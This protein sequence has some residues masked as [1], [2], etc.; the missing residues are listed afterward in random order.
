MINFMKKFIPIFVLVV[1][2]CQSENDLITSKKLETMSFKNHDDFRSVTEKLTA[3]SDVELDEWEKSNSFVSFR[4]VLNTAYKE[5]DLIT[6]EEQHN[7]FFKKYSD[8]L[9]IDNGSLEPTIK[10]AS[11]R[12]FVNREGLY[13]TEGYLNK[14][15]GDYIVSGPLLEYNRLKEL[16]RESQVL[17]KMDG[18]RVYEYTTSKEN[19]NGR[20]NAACGTNM[21]ASYFRNESNCR[22]DR[23]V[24]LY[25]NSFRDIVTN[26]SGTYYYPKVQIIVAP[27]KRSGTFCNWSLYANP[28]ELRNTS[29]SVRAYQ[30]I[31]FGST[32]TTSQIITYSFTLPYISQNNG[33]DWTQTIGDWTFNEPVSAFPFTSLHAEGKSQ[34]VGENGWAIID[35]Q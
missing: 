5:F 24:K 34:G 3:M 18:L 2:S 10:I 26:S 27:H 32:A 35:C 14:I 21:F 1:L 23:E 31:T 29:F 11:Q 30:R 28:T 4:S 13:E 6:T 22:N 19:T 33:I 20:T 17:G 16:K 9:K 15:I 7:Q 8:V 12:A 25:V